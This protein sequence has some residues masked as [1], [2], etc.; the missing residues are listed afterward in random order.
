VGGA[1]ADHP[2]LQLDASAREGDPPEVRPSL[3]LCHNPLSQP[4]TGSAQPEGFK[5]GMWRDL[6]G[7]SAGVV[8]PYSL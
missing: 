3:R 5:L 6:F 7:A 8:A 1:P 4:A 2:G